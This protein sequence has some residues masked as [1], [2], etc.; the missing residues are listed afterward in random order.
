MT[1]S[2]YIYASGNPLQ[3]TDPSGLW[4][5]SWS[6]SCVIEDVHDTSGVVGAAAS[7]CTL[8]AAISG[9]GNLGVSEACGAVALVAAGV[10]AGTSLTRYAQG[11]ESGSALA[12]DLTQD[13]ADFAGFGLA[14]QADRWAL[15]SGAL[16]GLSQVA[17]YGVGPL[18][19]RLYSL[20]FG[21]PSRMYAFA[22][23]GA[24]G[25]SWLENYLSF[26]YGTYGATT[27]ALMS[28]G[29]LTS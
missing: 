3:F 13:V 27:N 17:R 22:S 9:V 7:G 19:G 26:W 2:R 18:R 11:D 12:G 29:V 8:V 10:N 15:R 25:V 5:A 6:M 21:V 4:C 20:E 1:R 24:R 16:N 23:T 28:C 14:G